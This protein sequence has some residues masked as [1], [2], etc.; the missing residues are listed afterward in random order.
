[1][2]PYR[3]KQLKL[4]DRPIQTVIQDRPDATVFATR[5]DYA[6]GTTDWFLDETPKHAPHRANSPE[7]LME[8]VRQI[9]RQHG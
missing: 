1:M 8:R 7:A 4:E 2:E 6:N 3:G 5:K 9:Q